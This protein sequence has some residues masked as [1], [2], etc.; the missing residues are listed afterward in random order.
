ML[1]QQWHYLTP[2]AANVLVGSVVMLTVLSWERSGAHLAW[3]VAAGAF[4]LA[5]K[6]PNAVIVV[7]GVLYL[8][9]RGVLARRLDPGR[10]ATDGAE[11]DVRSPRRYAAAAAALLGGAAV[12]SVAWLVTRGALAGPGT[13]PMERDEQV[14][15]LRP[16]QVLENLARFITP[17]DREPSSLYPLAVLTSYLF[18]GSL[19]VA[20]VALSR[21]DRR[22][23]L[24]LATGVVLIAGPLLLVGVNFAVRGSYTVVQPRYG[25][26][27]VPIQCAIAATFWS[28][29]AR[30]FV[31]ALA[32]TAPVAVLLRLLV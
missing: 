5:I 4:A 27:L 10:S 28:G 3:L 9:G 17:W 31:A 23:S 18:V 13:S 15:M 8:V 12:A 21:R 16:S 24:A 25:S 2:D 7:T 19:L 6:A 1:L 11:D 26:T 30:R 20:L 22:Y 32:V 29:W 14:G